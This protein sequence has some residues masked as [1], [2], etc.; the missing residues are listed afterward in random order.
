M[1]TLNKKWSNFPV[2]NKDQE[3][4]SEDQANVTTSHKHLGGNIGRERDTK[5]DSEDDMAE[6]E[7]TSTDDEKTESDDDDDDY[8]GF[9]FWRKD[10]LCSIQDKPTI[11]KSWILLDSQPIVDVFFNPK[12]LNNI[13]GPKHTLALYCITGKTI[14][15]KKGNLKSY[16]TIWYHADGIVNILSLHHVQ[17]IHKVTYD[18]YQ[19]TCFVVHKV[20]CNCRVFMPSSKVALSLLLKAVSP[21][22]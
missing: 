18:S 2:L 15:N 22:S 17:K 16:G 9:E 7:G 5:S 14:I 8:E 13:Q 3:I 6:E 21:T 4:S 10:I 20:D 12:L 1:K 11:P 19:G